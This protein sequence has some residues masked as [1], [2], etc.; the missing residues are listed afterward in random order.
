MEMSF[1]LSTIFMFR[2]Q[3]LQLSSISRTPGHQEDTSSISYY[4]IV[5]CLVLCWSRIIAKSDPKNENGAQKSARFHFFR[6]IFWKSKYMCHPFSILTNRKSEN[7]PMRHNSVAGIN[8]SGKTAVSKIPYRVLSVTLAWPFGRDNCWKKV[9]SIWP[10][11]CL[12]RLNH[13]SFT[14]ST[15]DISYNIV[16]FNL[17]KDL[18]LLRGPKFRRESAEVEPK[19]QVFFKPSLKFLM[20]K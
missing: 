16:N 5:L 17:I 14:M 13:N 1:F 19:A 4:L 8:F 12:K 15:F 18:H 2:G 7:A 3:I 11:P 9:G 20:V 10:P 6:S